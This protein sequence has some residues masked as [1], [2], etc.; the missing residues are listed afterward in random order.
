[1]KRTNLLTLLSLLILVS[2]AL[3]ENPRDMRFSELTFDP[4]EP[5]RFETENGMVVYFLEYHDLPIV[6]AAA[7]FRG[8]DVHDP[9]EKIGLAEITAQLVRTGGAGDRTGDQVDEDLDFVGANIRSASHLEH[10]SIRLN[11]LIKDHELVFGILADMLMRPAFDADKLALEV[12]NLQ[13]GIRRQNDDSWSISRRVF[14]QTVYGDHPYGRFATLESSGRITRE[15]VLTQHR[16]FYAPDNC[17]LAITGDLALEEAKQLIDKHFGS[18]R[19]SGRRIEPI[20]PAAGS[21]TPGIYYA[22]KDINQANIRLGHLGLDDKHPDRFAMEV[23]NFAL[24]GGGFSS[25]MTSQ[26]RTTAGLAYSV[27]TIQ[28]T[29]PHRGLFFGYCLTRADAMSEAVRMMLE[30]IEDVRSNGIREEE[31]ELA[32]DSILNSYV[33]DYDTPGELVSARAQLELSGFPPDQLQRT[34]EAYKAVTLEDCN[35]VAREHLDPDHL[36]IVITGDRTQFDHP[37]ETLGPV[38]AVSMETR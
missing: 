38:T 23:M 15:D 13:D 9:S 17:I 30:I 25:R 4:A 18:W 34:L 35:R 19:R 26:I 29:F 12:S 6:A 14:R 10:L 27:G 37:P 36:A 20:S 2:A 3:A 7:Y 21:F 22:E 8:G 33:F 24:G 1:M 5:V 32:K 16:R 11:A 31:M 28:A